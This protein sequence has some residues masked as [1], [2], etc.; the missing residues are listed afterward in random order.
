V[1]AKER[2][3][4]VP[5]NPLLDKL[6]IANPVI[7]GP[8]GGGPST[9]ELVAAVSN[10]GGLGSLGA[11]YQKPEEITDTIRKIKSLTS[12]PFNVNLFAGG[13]DAK[14]LP[15]PKP[16]LDVLAEIHATLGLP[17]PTLPQ[18]PAD[19]FPAQLEAVLDADPP[20][21][22]FTFG[23]PDA[24]CLARLKARSIL[25]V[26]TATTVEEAKA[27]T[28]AGVDAIV[29]QGAEAGAHRGTFAG[30]F[31]ESM[32][33]TF[34]L[35]PAIRAAVSTPVIAA[36]GLMDGRDIHKALELGASAAALGTAFLASPEC[37]APQAHKQAVMAARSDT[38][39]ITRA[40]SGRPARG[41]KNAFIAQLAN[42]EDIILPYPLQ[43]I[44]TRTMRSAAASRG[45][46]E[47]LSLWACTGVAR[48]RALPAAALVK[49]LVDEIDASANT[50][51]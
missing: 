7:Q 17:A 12:K 11:A 37:G 4:L 40:F 50:A 48:A 46:S 39:V 3:R 31:Q 43:N 5:Q 49:Q 29:A 42:R 41:L 27:L 33:P 44:L 24:D 23:I 8:M 18:L 25:I 38:T 28:D 16:M 22:S 14:S 2:N 35:V 1:A 15:D 10:A 30:S 6:G 21:F 32:V 45:D 26:G 13:Y 36:G 19:P 20:I 9:P 34:D 47:Y 51:H